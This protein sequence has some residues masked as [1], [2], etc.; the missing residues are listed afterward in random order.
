MAEEIKIVYRLSSDSPTFVWNEEVAKQEMLKYLLGDYL[1]NNY[2]FEKIDDVIELKDMMDNNEN[3][4][5]FNSNTYSTIL[6]DGWKKVKQINISELQEE[7][8]LPFDEKR[9]NPF[10]PLLTRNRDITIIDINNETKRSKVLGATG[11][12]KGL[13]TEKEEGWDKG[14]DM[15]TEFEAYYEKVKK[16]EEVKVSRDNIKGTMKK[17]SFKDIV[18][19]KVAK[20]NNIGF[21]GVK[22]VTRKVDLQNT[23]EQII[24]RT[25]DGIGERITREKGKS[26]GQQMYDF[27]YSSDAKDKSIQTSELDKAQSK[28][29]TIKRNLKLLEKLKGAVDGLVYIEQTEDEYYDSIL[30]S[31]KG[32]DETPRVDNSKKKEFYRRTDI[33]FDL[34]VD[35]SAKEMD[36][37]DE[38][39]KL[40]DYSFLL[41]SKNKFMDTLIEYLYSEMS[42]ENKIYKTLTGLFK[43]FDLTIGKYSL[44]ENKKLGAEARNSTIKSVQSALDK[45]SDRAEKVY[46]ALVD[47]FPNIIEEKTNKQNEK[48]KEIEKAA[49]DKQKEFDEKTKTSE[50]SN[51]EA[52]E[53]YKD[54]ELAGKTQFSRYINDIDGIYE[55]SISVVKEDKPLYTEKQLDTFKKIID[56]NKANKTDKP[57]VSGKKSISLKDGETDWNKR[58]EDAKKEVDSKYRLDPISILLIGTLEINQGPAALLPTH[59]TKVRADNKGEPLKAKDKNMASR[60][61]ARIRKRFKSLKNILG[62]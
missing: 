21:I 38:I 1:Q 27:T 5:N 19:E 32:K 4:P 35:D 8:Q 11:S 12:D 44:K 36:L 57:V 50:S 31:T 9:G 3:N 2:N 37:V 17:F 25:A 47:D 42:E 10:Q 6:S 39:E 48:R 20:L 51:Q 49:R 61:F 13:L 7:T 54:I 34:Q 52:K 59:Q 46:I 14:S 58:L 29:I 22:Q 28:L 56:S 53:M 62:D 41:N 15:G 24:V 26:K 30:D 18:G 45:S 33:V 43:K 55:C 60:A 40:K 16:V 23:K